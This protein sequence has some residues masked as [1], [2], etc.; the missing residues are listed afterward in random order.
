M[1]LGIFNPLEPSSLFSSFLSFP[2]FFSFFLFLFLSFSRVSPQ[3][4]ELAMKDKK[5]ASQKARKRRDKPQA[6]RPV[7]LLFKSVNNY[8]FFCSLISLFLF[9]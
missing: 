1:L 3:L 5:F 4:I 6:A 7:G 2:F 8:L 9:S